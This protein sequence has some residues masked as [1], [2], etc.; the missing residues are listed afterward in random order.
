MKT[1]S[2]KSSRKEHAAPQ[3][4]LLVEPFS[5]AL[6]ASTNRERRLVVHEPASTEAHES[7]D[8]QAADS[9]AVEDIGHD[10]NV[11]DDEVLPQILPNSVSSPAP[12]SSE[13]ISIGGPTTPFTQDVFWE[14]HHP[15]SPLHEV[16]PRT[17]PTQVTTLVLETSQ[18]TPEDMEK[19]TPSP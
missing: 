8:I 17:P 1:K 3:E 12:T 4:P 15:N 13:L 11:E 10:D 2:S 14:K 7:E 6:P 19:T 5:V 18:A 16:I 9:T